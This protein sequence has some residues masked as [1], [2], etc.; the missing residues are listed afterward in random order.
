MVADIGL[1]GLLLK[2]YR[3]HPINYPINF[4][5]DT[6]ELHYSNFHSV[7]SAYTQQLVC[8]SHDQP[9]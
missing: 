1:L 2:D 5:N 3:T 6:S 7:E 8:R 9:S 4:T